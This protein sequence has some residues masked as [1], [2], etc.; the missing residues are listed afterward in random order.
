MSYRSVM[1]MLM[2][3][4]AGWSCSGSA[5]PESLDAAE[6]DTAAEAMVEPAAA[7]AAPPADIAAPVEDLGSDRPATVSLSLSNSRMYEGDYH[8]SGRARICGNAMR[9]MNGKVNGFNFEFPV[10]GDFEIVD[11]AFGAEELPAGATTTQYY[12]A[13]SVKAKRGGRPPSFVLRT[14]QP[15]F[16]EA[17][18]ATRSEEGGAIR[19][20]VEGVNDL[21]ERLQMTAECGPRP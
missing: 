7:P 3:A 12:L 2:I 9:A 16:H 20:V 18:R 15:Q 4:G 17:G 10:E 21:G 11:V 1:L 14:N 5:P 8:A 13:V 19:I 6:A